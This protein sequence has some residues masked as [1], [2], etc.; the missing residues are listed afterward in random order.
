MNGAVVRR[1]LW[2]S[3]SRSPLI[4]VLVLL[5]GFA[6]VALFSTADDQTEPPDWMATSRSRF[7]SPGLTR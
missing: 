6:L 5:W 1:I 4:A 7:G 2:I 3:V